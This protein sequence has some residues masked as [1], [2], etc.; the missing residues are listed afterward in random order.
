MDA[1]SFT[2]LLEKVSPLIT[3][4]TTT[5]REPITPDERRDDFEIEAE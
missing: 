1:A 3:K 5:M 4:K 2:E